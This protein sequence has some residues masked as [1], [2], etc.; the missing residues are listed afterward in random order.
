M[1]TTEAL[2]AA[3]LTYLV[4]LQANEQPYSEQKVAPQGSSHAH[5]PIYRYTPVST[6]SWV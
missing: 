6:H 2:Q 1:G 3:G 4:K 5:P